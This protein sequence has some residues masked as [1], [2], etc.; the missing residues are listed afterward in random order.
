MYPLAGSNG[1]SL[2]MYPLVGF[3]F[4]AKGCAVRD[5]ASLAMHP[6]WFPYSLARRLPKICAG[7]FSFTFL[8]KFLSKSVRFGRSLAQL[9]LAAL[10]L[11]PFGLRKAKKGALS[12]VFLRDVP[13]GPFFP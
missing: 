12:S 11:Y 7:L 1:A 3:D 13:F 9:I 2:A 10:S 5:G 4:Q 6:G 8:L